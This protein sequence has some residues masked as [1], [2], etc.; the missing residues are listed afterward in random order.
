MTGLWW[1]F[2]SSL[3]YSRPSWT[4]SLRCTNS[5]ITSLRLIRDLIADHKNR[6]RISTSLTAVWFEVSRVLLFNIAAHKRNTQDSSKTYTW[7]FY[8]KDTLRKLGRLGFHVQNLLR[9]RVHGRW[10]VKWNSNPAQIRPTY[11]RVSL[12]PV[13]KFFHL[14]WEV[15]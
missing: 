6:S 14:V 5:G 12:S 8:T 13:S 7:N 11:A 15:R 4:S 9:V 2:R 10:T 1:K 3:V